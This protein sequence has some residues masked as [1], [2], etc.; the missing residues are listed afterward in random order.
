MDIGYTKGELAREIV[1]LLQ[2]QYK[3]SNTKFHIF[4]ITDSKECKEVTWT[5]GNITLHQ[6]HQ[7]KIENIDEE[8]AK[9]GFDLK[10]KLDL[11]VSRWTLRHLI[12]PFGT[13]TKI[14]DLLNP[15]KGKLIANGFLFKYEDSKKVQGFT[16]KHQNIVSQSNASAIFYDYDAGRDAGHFLLDRNDKKTARHSVRIY[17]QCCLYFI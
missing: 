16:Y 1:N 4:S 14:Y 11:I 2:A 5:E 10:E 12:D 13:L 6:L 3:K 15:S 17:W 9:R 8:I 7:F